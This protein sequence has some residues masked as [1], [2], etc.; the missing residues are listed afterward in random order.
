M[1]QT[2]YLNK[3]R[4]P[5]GD[6]GYCRSFK[7]LKQMPLVSLSPQKFVWP[8]LCY[9]PVGSYEL[10][11]WNF[12][13]YNI[14]INTPDFVENIVGF[15]KLKEEHVDTHMVTYVDSLFARRN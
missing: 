3:I 5:R 6:I 13:M 4:V 10:Q 9:C 8:L 1:P 14:K 7:A 15:Q 12:I 2:S 11:S